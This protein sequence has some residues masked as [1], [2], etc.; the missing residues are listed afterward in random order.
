MKQETKRGLFAS[1][2]LA[3]LAITM[4]TLAQA[5]QAP[6]PEASS[7]EDVVIVTGTR[8]PQANL[9]TTSPVT[10]VTAEDLTNAG[11]TRVED[12]VNQLPQAFAAQNATVVNGASGAATVSLR[13]IGSDRTLV[14]IDGRRM[15][16]G[17]INDSAADLNQIPGA[18]VERV[19]VLTGGASAVYGSDAIA[20]VVNFIMRKDFEGVELDAQYGFY[21]HNNDYDGEGNL[22]SV[23]AGRARTNPSQFALPDDNQVD[24]YSKQIT[25]IIGASTPDGKGNVTAYVSYRNNDEI[26]QRYRDYSACSLGTSTGVNFTC[27]GSGTNATG[28]FTDFANFAYTLGANGEFR[29]FSAATD[30]YNFG[31][32]NYFQRPDERYSFG[33]FGY[34]EINKHA[35]VYT[36]LMFT[37]YQ[38]VAQIAPSGNFFSTPQGINCSNPLLSA[39]QQAALCAIDLVPDIVDDPD[40][41][42][43]EVDDF[44]A[45]NP[46]VDA[47][48]FIAA[49]LGDNTALTGGAPSFD[50][51]GNV[52]I[53]SFDG[54]S[55]AYIARRNVEGG[56]RQDTIGL[57]TYRGVIGVKGEITEGWNYDLSATYATVRQSR[58]YLNDFSVARLT[59]ALD[60]V[61]DPATGQPACASFVDGTDTNCVPYNIF[62]VGGVTP[63]ALSYL[64]IPLI[65]VGSTTV[66]VVNGAVT[67]DLG[68]I[69]LVSPFASTPFATAFGVEYR[70][71]ELETTTDTAFA[72]GD[73]A[74][75]GGPT[76]GLQG[77]TESVDF[78]A[79][80]QMPLVEDMPFAHRISADIAYRNSDYGNIT[81]DTY[82]FGGDWAPVE[83]FRMRGSYQRAV[84]APNVIELFTGQGLGLY[85]AQ[86]DPCGPNPTATRA[87]CVATGVPS[88]QYGSAALQSPANQYNQLTGG[89]PDLKPETADTYTLGFVFSPSAFLEGLTVS[90]DWFQIKLEDN[91]GTLG[92][93]NTLSSCY[94]QN[95]QAACAR[96]NRN[97]QGQLWVGD[98]FVQNLN[99]NTGGL[100]TS[101]YD[102]VVD[103][104]FDIAD[105]GLP[106]LGSI[107]LSL[108]GTYLDKLKQQPERPLQ[109]YDCAGFYGNQCG[110]PNPEWR[111]RASVGWE[112]PWNVELVGT[113][114]YYGEV[115]QFAANFN[116]T[117]LGTRRDRYFDAENYFD[118][119]GNWQIRDNANLR[120]GVNNILDDDPQLSTVAATG[121]NGNT[122]PQTYDALGRY[123][124][125]GIKV[126]F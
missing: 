20:G 43:N 126:N 7:D 54:V 77:A 95:N 119:T 18:L 113:W 34:Y 84:R 2:V 114:R 71:N 52:V 33:A 40:T 78:F 112:T 85:S 38:S 92:A 59:K 15:P 109:F 13:G 72:T 61:V 110:T 4:P 101:G 96:I 87:Q 107:S 10:Q 56:G 82:K 1:T 68:T 91:I 21:Q 8:I 69:G 49:T 9:V 53:T 120:F 123:V 37:D 45:D 23:I 41:P 36:Q 66:S 81:S 64:Q 86:N 48:G 99:V 115:E 3:G 16:Y 11:V 39:G 73:G 108:V 57:E 42:E 106:D 83:S 25:G 76:L 103:Y 100:L 94:Q 65:Q 105:T 51:D 35:E 97:P 89:N 44:I 60:V 26:S 67:G 118:L 98:S 14:L 19:E 88:S 46:D 124:F 90:V 93:L 32:I 29:N 17:T 47:V 122:Y 5:Q 62:A 12:L 27:G 63:A 6:A 117:S 50:D 70:R 30:Q 79:E 28:Q 58:V 22:R 121:G 74:G 80:L 24:G 104:N 116:Q 125:A 55:P 102:L 111:H 31:P 75:Q